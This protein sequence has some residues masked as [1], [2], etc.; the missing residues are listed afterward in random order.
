MHGKLQRCQTQRS[1]TQIRAEIKQTYYLLKFAITQSN[2][3]I[4]SEL[5]HNTKCPS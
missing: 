3:S 5:Q 1:D 4:F 2:G